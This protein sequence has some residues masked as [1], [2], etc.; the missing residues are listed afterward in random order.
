MPAE[1]RL[2][3]SVGLSFE[4]EPATKKDVG[5]REGGC[6]KVCKSACGVNGRVGGA[7]LGGRGEP[8]ALKSNLSEYPRAENEKKTV[9]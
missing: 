6:E 2:G 5:G 3:V 4:W 9:F 1:V 7:V 8:A